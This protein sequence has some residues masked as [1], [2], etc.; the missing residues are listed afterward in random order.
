[1]DTGFAEISSYINTKG[2]FEFRFSLF[3]EPNLTTIRT[4]IF[5]ARVTVCLNLGTYLSRDSITYSCTIDVSY[6]FRS[7]ELNVKF[8]SLF[9]HV[10][11]H[12]THVIKLIE[13]VGFSELNIQTKTET[14]I[15]N[16]N[17]KRISHEI[18][19]RISE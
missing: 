10:A 9:P 4:I 16:N 1:M 6:T 3:F 12:R 14:K 17:N 13:S 5:Y 8:Q 2:T 18:K 19:K 7:E 11:V 15:I